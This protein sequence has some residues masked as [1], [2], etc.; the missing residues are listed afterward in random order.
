M[1]DPDIVSD[2]DNLQTNVLHTQDVRLQVNYF[3]VNVNLLMFLERPGQSMDKGLITINL[4]R[5]VEKHGGN[6]NSG[7]W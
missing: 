5:K 6:E 7:T 1:Q 2:N 3:V 4:L